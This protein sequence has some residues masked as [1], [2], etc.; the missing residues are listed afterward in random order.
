MTWCEIG[1]IFAARAIDSD[2]AWTAQEQALHQFYALLVTLGIAIVAGILT[3]FLI[4]IGGS[5]PE[6]RWYNDDEFWNLP[7]EHNDHPEDH[8]GDTAADGADAYNNAS[9]DLGIALGF[10]GGAA[11]KPTERSV[12]S[13]TT[14]LL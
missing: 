3:G 9:A 4:N 8:P 7:H 13:V 6:H 10:G 11:Q 14:S 5:F 1:T 2:T 12:R